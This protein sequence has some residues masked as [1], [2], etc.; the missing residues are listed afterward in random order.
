MIRKTVFLFLIVAMSASY[1]QNSVSVDSRD[2]PVTLKVE[3][4]V[5]DFEANGAV[6]VD[7]EGN[8]FVSQYGVY[9]QSGGNGTKTIKVGPS[10]AVLRTLDDLSGPMGSVK[11]SK[12]NIFIN[13]DNNTQRGIVLKIDKKGNRTEFAK[14]TGWPSGMAI[15]KNDALYITNY[16]APRIDRIDS[17][18]TVTTFAEDERLAGCVGIDFTNDGRLVVSNFFSATIFLIDQ[19]GQITELVSMPEVIVQGWGIGYLT[20]VDDVIYATGIAVSKVFRVTL[21]G[22]HQWFAGDGVAKS[23]DGDL[24]TASLSNPNGIASDKKKKILYISEY[25]PGGGLRKIKL[26]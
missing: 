23:V 20:V 25:G 26:N 22:S 8:V 1:G 16:A 2:T 11:D 5:S 12:G 17:E 14:L 6:S 24:K 15:D 10:G 7:A 13:N 3:T 4:V 21:D 9:V 19:V 18:G